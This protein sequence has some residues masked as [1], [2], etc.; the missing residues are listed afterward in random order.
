[1]CICISSIYS[2]GKDIDEIVRLS[3]GRALKTPQRNEK[4]KK[5][6]IQTDT[7]GRLKRPKT[8][9]E[10]QTETTAFVGF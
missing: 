9:I 3:G 8:E 6:K 10:T 5:K 7:Q 2:G 4:K 1:M